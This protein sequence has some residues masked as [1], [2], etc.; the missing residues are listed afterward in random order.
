MR[1]AVTGAR[2]RLGGALIR[3]LG[4]DG[5]A[6]GRTEVDL[7][8]PGEIEAPFLRDRPEAVVHAAA[9]TD[10]DGCAGNP[11]LA[12]QR[13]GAA[14]GRLARACAS[15]GVH[16]VVIST[17]EVFDGLRSDGR[18]YAADDT[19]SPGNAYGLS[20]LAGERAA[21]DAF[22]EAP[23]ALAIV[24]TA[25]LFGPPGRDFPDKILDAAARAAATGTPLRLV[26]D[27]F[28][29]PT[30]VDD[31]AAAILALLGGGLPTAIHHVTN[32]GSTTRADWARE[33][34]RLA[35]VSDV[36]T[37]DVPSRTWSRPS[38]PPPRAVLE[39]TALPDGMTLPSWREATAAYLPVLLRARAEREGGIH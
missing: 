21:L 3:A 31:L 4:D 6:W 10:V 2:G 7:D 34:L 1:V 8:D 26:D 19:P 9:W 27:E 24:R 30:S 35:D 29:N 16:L 18:A 12:H 13:N 32:A 15:R 39:P 5:I 14:T 33:I 36:P 17:N 11:D 22:A 23:A 37:E 28:G 38:V 25:W 20:K